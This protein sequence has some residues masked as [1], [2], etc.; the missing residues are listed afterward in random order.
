[1]YFFSS[2]TG[3]T[4]QYWFSTFSI[5]LDCILYLL[6]PILFRSSSSALAFLLITYLRLSILELFCEFCVVASSLYDYVRLSSCSL[7]NLLY[8]LRVLDYLFHDSFVISTSHRYF[9]LVQKFY[10]VRF[11]G[12]FSEDVYKR[13]VHSS[14]VSL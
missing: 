2:S 3:V 4:T 6:T 5:S 14:F 7:Q 1:M 10:S 11:V 12:I 13:Q 8:Q 9:A